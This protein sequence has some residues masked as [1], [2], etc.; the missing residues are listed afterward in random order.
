M[1]IARPKLSTIVQSAN[2]N[3]S[4]LVADCIFPQ[5]AV[6]AKHFSYIDFMNAENM[7]RIV[8][9]S[10][11][12]KS[13]VKEVGGEDLKLVDAS[14]KD[15]ALAQ[16]LGE[17]N[18]TVC[19]DEGRVIAQLEAAKTRNLLNK[20]LTSREARAIALAT[21]TTKFGAAVTTAPTAST[22]IDGGYY[23][24]SATNFNDPNYGLRRY[25]QGFQEYARYGQFNTMVTD[26]A[27]LNTMLSHP[28]FIGY[29]LVPTPMAS[30]QTLA[31][32]LGV[33]KICIADATYNDGVGDTPA[34][35]RFWPTGT[36]LFTKSYG[37]SS[38][39]EETFAFGI[40][41]YNR[42]FQ[43]FTWLDENKGPEEGVLMQKQSH[44]LTEVVLSYNA[45]LLVKVTP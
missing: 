38:T 25:F 31:S 6:G 23:T 9:D 29:G 8:D 22:Q 12:C 24:I 1:I 21:D 17:C 43:Q 14:L 34:M 27:T 3:R 2:L 13:N 37:M 19:G 20:L 5:V 30:Q 4:G 45:A 32:L 26:L 44:D 11:T 42:G 36:I 33:Q 7:A 35:K 10:V 28:Q 40:S 16:S 18:I 15:H 41:A 39:T